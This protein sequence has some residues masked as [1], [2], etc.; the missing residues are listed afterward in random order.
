[1]RRY[2]EP[3]ADNARWEGFEFRDGDVVIAAPSKSGTT[4]TQ[5]L[6][7]LLVFDGPD[8]PEPIGKMSLWMDQRTRPVEEAH[9]TFA[10]Q[11]HRR[12][13]KTHTP[14]DG[15]PIFEGARY[16]CVGRDPRDAAISM[17]H[18]ADN[19]DREA[20]NALLAADA[21]PDEEQEQT[22]RPMLTFTER[23]DRFIDGDEFPGWN[24]RFLAHHYTTFWEQRGRE[25][26][27]LFHFDDYRRDLSAELQRLAAHLGIEVSGERAVELAAE[28][29]IERVRSRATDVAPEA[30]LGVWKD[31]T[32]FFRSGKSGQWKD[33]FTPAQQERYGALVEELV[34]EDLAGWMHGGWGGVGGV[35]DES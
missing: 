7:A 4:W 1:M 34:P 2:N 33:E 23:I 3:D 24:L 20:F 31:T 22:P 14:L 18:H 21:R 35:V 27:A 32:R 25:N 29:Q 30:H 12:L 8:F 26:V 10:A 16:A 5:L 19:M 6:V 17:L 9:A 11:E 15:V 28:A 13:I